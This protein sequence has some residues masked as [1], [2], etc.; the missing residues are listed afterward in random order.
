[1]NVVALMYHDLARP[2]EEDTSGFPGGD[3]A[4]YKLTPDRFL[5]HLGAI[6]RRISAGPTTV[7][8]LPSA[9]GPDRPVP[10]LLT[11]D[12]GGASAEAIAD[13]LESVGWRGHFFVTAGYLDRPSFLA[14]R[15]VR[16]LCDRGHVVGS[17]SWSHPLRMAHCS[18]ARLR[19]EWKRSTGTL[20][21]IAGTPVRTASVP[22][23]DH[24]TLVA[25]T[26]I[27]AGIQWLFTSLPTIRAHRLD[28]CW[29][30]GRYAIQRS[31]SAAT[32]AALADGDVAPRLRQR[33]AW[34]ARQICKTLGG[35]FYLRAR[36]RILGGSPDVRWGDE[37]P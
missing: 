3:A 19:E 23:G 2:G 12:D 36:N 11:F 14:R 9:G 26:A 34:D 32:A 13:H 21:E 16:D 8:R 37:V 29:I 20:G 1:M 7:D 22:G 5:D 28:G 25:H 33:A 15:A 18:P 35:S 6:R 10:L 31:M 27:E 4:R 17:H 24:S 30:L